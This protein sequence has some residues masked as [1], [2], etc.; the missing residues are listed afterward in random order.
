MKNVKDKKKILKA[1][2]EK[3]RVIYKGIPIRLFSA[4]ILQAR[5]EWP[6]ISKVLKVKNLQ[7]RIVYLA[8]LSLRNEGEIQNF[9]VK[10][11]L[12]QFKTEQALKEVLKGLP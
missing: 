4:E 7:P 8:R 6:D 10:Q 3:Q 2:R 5:R 9:S 11:K 12:K 1:V